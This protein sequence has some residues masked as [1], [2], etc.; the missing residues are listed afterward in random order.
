MMRGTERLP[1]LA[2]AAACALGAACAAVGAC[3]GSSSETPWPM[4]PPNL[5]LGPRG[6]RLPGAAASDVARPVDTSEPVDDE[7]PDAG[8][9]A[10]PSESDLE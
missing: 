3:G 4:E 1:I 2:I 9:D 5:R 7:E 6:E 10:G 8:S